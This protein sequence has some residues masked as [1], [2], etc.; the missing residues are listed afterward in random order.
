M[1]GDDSPATDRLNRLAEN[2][3]I[4]CFVVPFSARSARISPTTGANLNP[5]PEN[6]HATLTCGN[7][8]WTSIT[9]CRSGVT[10]YMHTCPFVSGPR[11]GRYVSI[12]GRIAATS[13]SVMFQ[14]T[15]SGFGN[16]GAP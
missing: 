13:A 8:G 9:K 6:P 10:V 15:P 16:S 11:P 12:S 1:T 3:P 2:M 5:W 7:R 14:F 4:S